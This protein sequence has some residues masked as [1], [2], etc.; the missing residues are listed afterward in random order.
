MEDWVEA[1]R[2]KDIDR[3]VLHY[4]KDV[5]LFDLAPPLQYTGSDALRKS[6]EEW[7]PTFNGRIGYEICGLQ[8]STGNDTAFSYSLAISAGREQTASLSFPEP[9]LL[10]R[11]NAAA[12]LQAD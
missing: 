10:D 11:E 6:L 1:V 3:C 2:A 7:F 5:L 12:S 4:A 9:H 8:I